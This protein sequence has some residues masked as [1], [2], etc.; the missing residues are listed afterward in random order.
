MQMN[1]FLWYDACMFLQKLPCDGTGAQGRLF[2][3]CGA[4]KRMIYVPDV[5]KNL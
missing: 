4:A 1:A 5:G 2:I 3:V